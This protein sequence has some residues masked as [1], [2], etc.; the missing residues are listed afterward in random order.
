[1]TDRQKQALLALATDLSR[2]DAG[3]IAAIKAALDNPPRTTEEVGYYVSQG[4]TTFENCFRKLVSL[5]SE[6]PYAMSVED[7]YVYEIFAHWT[8]PGRLEELPAAFRDL[9]PDW[10]GVE[11]DAGDEDAAEEFRTTLTAGYVEGVKAVERA[12]E[13]LGAPLLSFD[14]G[15]SDTMVFIQATPE[16]AD[17]WRNVKLGESHDGETLAVRSPMWGVLWANISYAADVEL[18]D[19]PDDLPSPPLRELE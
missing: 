8:A 13:E 5:L 12:F 3:V 16:V 19:P 2:G 11:P 10:F 17:R 14:T 4:N 15:S 9:F 7:K 6:T 18:E 1:M